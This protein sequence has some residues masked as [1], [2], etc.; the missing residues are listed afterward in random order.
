MGLTDQQASDALERERGGMFAIAYGMLGSAAEA[1]DVV[2]EAFVRW[3]GQDRSAVRS[4]AA[5]LTTTVTRLA[6]DRLRSAE[7]RRVEYVGPW[8][9]EPLVSEL[10]AAEVASE[11]EQLSLALLAALER[12]QSD[13]A[14]GLPAAR[15]LRLR[16]LQDR[17]DRRQDRGELPTDRPPRPDTGR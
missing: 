5:F 7:R 14:C 15:R 3:H 10:D 17:G 12:P 4:P 2:Q 6:I 9:P 11:A 13:R 1:E 8:L 16:L